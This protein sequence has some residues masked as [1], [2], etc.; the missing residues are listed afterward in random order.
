[1][2]LPVVAATAI[3]CS[4][5]V[6][7]VDTSG[8]R[9]GPVSITASTNSVIVSWQDERGRA[10]SAAF[11]LE[12]NRP[13]VAA[14]RI[15]G[16]AIVENAR[17][18]YWA[19]TGKRRGGWDQFFD[20]P[21]S[22]PDGTRRF[23]SAYQPRAARVKST[24]NRVELY[25]DGLKLGI[26]EGGI[27]YTFYPGTRLIQQTAV[28]STSEPDTAYF[29]DA[30]FQFAAET[31]RRAGNNMESQVSYFDTEGKLRAEAMMGPER[32]PHAVRYRTL[33]ART[34]NGSIAVFP[35]PHQYFFARDFTTNMAHL[36]SRAWRGQ[37]GLGIRQLPDDNTNFYPWMNAPPGTEQRMSLFLQI[38]DA[39]PAALLE[40]VLRYTSRDRYPALPGYKTLASHWHVAY[41]VQA[42]EKGFD[43]T[44]PF[45]P[46]LKEMGVDMAMIADFHG[47]GHPRDTGQVRLKELDAYYRACGAQSD[48]AFLLI[49]AEEAN[50]HLGGHYSVT[51][52]KPVYWIM[53][54]ADGEPFLSR[55][56]P[57]GEVYRTKDA[58]DVFAMVKKE[59][60]FVYQTHPRTKGS[61]GFP[62]KVREE[63]FFRDASYFGAGFKAMPSDLSTPR[64][65]LRALNLLDDMNN[66][67][68]RKRL[69]GE[70]DVFQIDHTHELYA[71]MNV[72]YVRLPALPR[73]EEYGKVLEAM[74]RGEFFVTTGEVLL[75]EVKIT[76]SEVR[77]RVRWTMPLQ[78]AVLVWGDGETTRREVI[79]LEATAPSG[80]QEF[81]W[82][83]DG[84][85]AKWTRLEVWDV[86]GSG[87]FVNPVRLE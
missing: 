22:H 15:D 40:E 11:S 26:F 24:G 65:G 83:F 77:A 27:A 1:M 69:L 10:C 25:F 74:Q 2:K 49:P 71:H 48:G 29:Y 44:P 36:W 19:E 20:L 62:D 50:A 76:R 57:F 84:R 59:N 52:P 34:A 14:I 56:E 80:E 4:A 58:A 43:W 12:A 51:F 82:R 35:A 7:P 33:A 3:L 60:G 46:V 5:Q 21:P 81:Q 54:R 17:P 30:G 70:V 73:F 9:P 85:T 37:I 23:Q 18:L 41:T 64:Q 16:K 66:W 55:M 13:L 38:S 47:D 39:T 86:A 87:A 8:V 6:I 72:S 78:Q 63:P 31:D 28:V 45:K 68:L 75:P 42:M 79:S 32:Q 67:G 61:M 53:S